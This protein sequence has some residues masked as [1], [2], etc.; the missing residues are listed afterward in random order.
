MIRI[1]LV[2]NY[3]ESVVAHGAIP[4]AIALSARKCRGPKLVAEFLETEKI[5]GEAELARLEPGG[6][7]CVP[8]S[9]YNKMDGALTAIR[10]ARERQIPFFGT[11]GGFQHAL[12][13]FARNVLGI[14][15][16]DHAESNPDAGAPIVSKLSC[17]LVE[18]SEIISLNPGS[19]VQR[20]YGVSE[21]RE[22]YHCNYGMNPQWV[23]RFEGSDLQFVAFTRGEPRAFELR[24]HP[25]FVGTLFQPERSATS[26]KDHP[27]INAFVRAVMKRGGVGV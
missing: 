23:D 19:E 27:L 16:A 13:E 1:V 2:G 4:A 20:S 6:I 21:I 25:F 14:A 10:F 22:E 3:D 8:G 15:N 17:S 24:G 7:W 12:I 26:G 18:K 11:C 9:P 5:A